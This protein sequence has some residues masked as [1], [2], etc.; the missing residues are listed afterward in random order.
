M[1]DPENERAP[2]FSAYT[3][4]GYEFTI[5]TR[6]LPYPWETFRYWAKVTGVARA[7]APSTPLS[8]ED[9][10]FRPVA[11]HGA[12]EADV[13]EKVTRHIDDWFERAT[14]PAGSTTTPP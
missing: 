8:L 12:T 1:G 14:P 2:V 10:P 9:L 3:R 13:I 11:H 6:F 5:E 7:D 4:G